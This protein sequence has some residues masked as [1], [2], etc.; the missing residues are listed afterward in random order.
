MPPAPLW[1][2]S[3][4]RS[5]PMGPG[6]VANCPAGPFWRRF[7][8]SSALCHPVGEMARPICA[9]GQ[10]PDSQARIQRR[11]DASRAIAGK[12]SASFSYRSATRPKCL[13]L[14]EESLDLVSLAV[15]GLAEAGP[16]CAT[17]F[18]RDI[19]RSAL[20]LEQVAD[21]AGVTSFVGQDDGARFGTIEPPC[22]GRTGSDRDTDLPHP[23]FRRSLLIR[24]DGNTVDHLDVNITSRCYCV[25]QP[26]TSTGIAPPS[27]A[28]VAGR[29]RAIAFRQVTPGAPDRNTRK[30]PFSTRR[31][32]TCGAP[33]GL[34]V[35][36]SSITRHQRSVRPYRLIPFPDQ[37]R[38]LSGILFMG[39]RPGKGRLR[40]AMPR[41]L[42]PAACQASAAAPGRQ[43]TSRSL[44]RY[45]N[46]GNP[47][48]LHGRCRCLD[49]RRRAHA[50][51]ASS[52]C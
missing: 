52:A 6:P 13:E 15:E 34:S 46:S 17:G 8:M 23:F 36:S 10:D 7:R 41:I 43:R 21:V 49:S 29:A 40:T 35:T 31:S 50:T 37:K 20:R 27:E 19:G 44:V 5:D 28:I 24:P 48:R 51:R 2:R 42:N 22:R 3:A 18:G 39:S 26:I 47:A 9:A 12:F 33:R 30:M 38:T 16:P 1:A 14:A 11:I 32:S 45:R 25:H 4:T